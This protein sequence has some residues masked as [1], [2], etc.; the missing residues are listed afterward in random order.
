MAAWLDIVREGEDWALVDTDRLGDLVRGIPFPERQYPDLIYFTGYKSRIRALR[1][2]LPQNNVTR[3]GA[4]RLIR[5]HINHKAINT[6]TPLMIAESSLYLQHNTGD[7]KWLRHT[8]TKHR[9][10]ILSKA[11]DLSSTKS[12]QEETKRQLVL[13]WTRVL[14]LFVE[15]ESDLKATQSLLQQPHR[16]LQVGSRVIRTSPEVIIIFNKNIHGPA[17]A[18]L[19][20]KKLHQIVEG[21]RIIF[22]D[23]SS[24]SSLSNTIA[25]KPL[26]ALISEKLQSVHAEDEIVCGRFSAFHLSSFWGT[27]VPANGQLWKASPL[28]LLA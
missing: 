9:K 5:L 10:Y 21:G 27:S 6:D 28:D 8:T 22:L 26:W 19:R 16:Q 11:G 4:N 2:F 3:K 17:I 25:F 14:C 24:R 13:P 23:L 1:S 7:T 15:S 18:L 20:Y 12:I